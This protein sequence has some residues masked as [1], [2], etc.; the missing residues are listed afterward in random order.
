[1]IGAVVGLLLGLL[2]A[3]KK[4]TVWDTLAT[5]ISVIGVSVPSYVF[6]LALSYQ[7]GFKLKWFPMLFSAKDVI[8]S[9]VLPSIVCCSRQTIRSVRYRRVSH[10]S[11]P[12]RSYQCHDLHTASTRWNSYW[13]LSRRNP[14]EYS[15]LHG[16]ASRTLIRGREG[17]F[18]SSSLPIICSEGGYR[19]TIVHQVT[20]SPVFK[21]IT[22]GNRLLDGITGDIDSVA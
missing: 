14:W 9:S 8:G 2:A 3:F 19:K 18:F 22:N 7:F 1:M 20:V 13:G 12:R 15:R 10:H 6:A 16:Q 11:P 5:I 4:D 17:Y 21:S